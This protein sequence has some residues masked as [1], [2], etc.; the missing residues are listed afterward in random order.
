MKII[1]GGAGFVIALTAGVA[2]A[3]VA[4]GGSN[5]PVT[6]HIQRADARSSSTS[7]TNRQ[8][9][10]KSAT[11]N[12]PG[13]GGAPGTPGNTSGHSSTTTAGPGK[14]SIVPARA[15]IV[16]GSTTPP[17]SGPSPTT[18]PPAPRTTPHVMI[19][20]MEN[21]SYG[22]IIGNSSVPYFN[23]LAQSYVN[24]TQSY[25]IAHPSLPNYLEITSA[26][27]WGVSDD[28]TP[29]SDPAG[30]PNLM[31]QLDSAGLSWAGFMESMPSCGYTG[32]DTGGDDGYGN[33]IYQ[34]HHNPFVYYSSIASEV[35][36][37]CPLGNMIGALDSA[38]PP[39]FVFVT[40]NMLD[41]WHDGSPS[42]GDNWLSQ[43]VPAI[44]ATT[45]YKQGGTIII[46]TDEG[47]SGDSSGIANDNGGHI[48]T[49]LVSQSLQ[50][51]GAYGT[52]VDQAGIVRS[53]EQLWGLP[54]V[55]DA[56]NGSH[57]NLANLLG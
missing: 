19:I 11:A 31:T 47:N 22:D 25:A 36:R 35:G 54:V 33:Q 18:P 46:T 10:G 12:N 40:P 52:P 41:D 13:T 30:S 48:P 34:Q 8:S 16:P 3:V 55:S 9:S 14:A 57:G 28:G 26:S 15:T 39:D 23:S 29:Q 6:D 1:A 7:T 43:E 50:G 38:S 49:V 27:T 44:Q 24:V 56:A 4:S 51:H 32:G 2:E 45:W 21:S 53:M 37:V 17:P 20:M 5:R 42:Q